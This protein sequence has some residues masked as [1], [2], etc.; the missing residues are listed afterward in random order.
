MLWASNPA[1]TN[2]SVDAVDLAREIREHHETVA[3]DAA[4]VVFLGLSDVDQLDLALGHQLGHLLGRVVRHHAFHLIEQPTG[5]VSGRSR[6]VPDSTASR[7]SRS[8]S[9]RSP[10]LS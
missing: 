3:G 5:L 2:A 10:G 4:G 9:A 6:I 7:A 8:H 1:P